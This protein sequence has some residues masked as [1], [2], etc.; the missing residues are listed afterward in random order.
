MGLNF[1]HLE[2]EDTPLLIGATSVYLF[3]PERLCVA[4]TFWLL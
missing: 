4:P 2:P 3:T 1:F